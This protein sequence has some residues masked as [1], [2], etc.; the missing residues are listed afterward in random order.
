MTLTKDEYLYLKGKWSSH[1]RASTTT[2]YLETG[3]ACYFLGYT[4]DFGMLTPK[5]EEA[6]K[7]YEGITYALAF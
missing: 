6:I 7:R 3:R 1:S 2:E 4:D 5:G